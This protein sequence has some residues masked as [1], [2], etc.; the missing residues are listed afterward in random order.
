[1]KIKHIIR[2]I[3]LIGIASIIYLQIN[4]S[5]KIETTIPASNIPMVDTEKLL[6]FGD[7]SFHQ[8]FDNDSG[9]YS[10]SILVLDISNPEF[11]EGYSRYHPYGTDSGVS[12]ILGTYDKENEV[13][14]ATESS[15]GE[16]TSYTNSQIWKFQDNT[17]ISGYTEAQLGGNIE[18]YENL[19][20]VIWNTDFPEKPID[21]SQVD[22]WLDEMYL[23]W[24]SYSSTEK[25]DQDMYDRIAVIM[26]NPR[27]QET[28]TVTEKYIDADSNW[29]TQE[30]LFFLE[31][32]DYCGSGGCT[33]VMVNGDDQVINRF[34]VTRK[35][36]L[37]QNYEKSNQWKDIVVWSDGS[38]RLLEHTDSGYPTNPS[39]APKLSDRDVEWHP[40]K[41]FMIM[42]D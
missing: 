27:L 13:I 1:M 29:E 40:E 16:G 23:Q 3:I 6:C 12:S 24:E 37:M 25:N 2:T 22:E 35:P 39:M 14:R 10:Y 15:Y 17:L 20:E 31:G 42:N 8:Y 26:D 38:Y 36:I 28:T 32:P 33:V 11:V 7:R 30:Y 5:E 21:C 18:D 41:Y 4:K 34:T 19:D 9:G